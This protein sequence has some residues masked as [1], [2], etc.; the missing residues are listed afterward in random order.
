MKTYPTYR[1]IRKQAMVLGLPISFFALQMVSVIGSLLIIIFSF[2]FGVIVGL[3]LF[4]A[5]LYG[6]LGRWV[7]KPFPVKVKN[8]FPSTI[9]N[10][11]LSPLNHA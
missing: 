9:S 3:L 8:T 6:A 2:H 5:L 1:N 10:K 7:K 11:R 4:N